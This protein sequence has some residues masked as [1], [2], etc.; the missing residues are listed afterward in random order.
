LTAGIFRILLGLVILSF[1]FVLILRWMNPPTSMMMTIRR[2]EA[3]MNQRK[4]FRI[5]YR[6]ADW[7]QIALHLPLATVAS[8]DQISQFITCRTIRNS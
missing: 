2:S 1:L 3:A 6:W 5:D 8:E 4:D 7:D